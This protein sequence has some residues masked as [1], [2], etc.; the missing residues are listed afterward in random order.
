MYRKGSFGDRFSAFIVDQILTLVI[1]VILAVI[2]N[3]LGVNIGID[4]YQSLL[5]L[6]F[7]VYSTLFV[8]RSG[9][10]VGK[11]L[12][13][14]KVV[15]MEYKPVG[16]WRALLRE[17]IGKI[18]SSVFNLGYLW[19]IIDK[20]KQAWHDKLTRTLVVKLDGNGNMVPIQTEE[21]VTGKK[22]LAFV[23][24]FLVVGIPSLLAG[25]FT[26]VYLF[27]GSPIKVSGSAMNP[28]YVN[29][30]YYLTNKVAYRTSSPQRNDIVVFKNP[31]NEDQDFL[32][33]I[34]GIPGDQIKIQD[35]KAFVNNQ[36]LQEPYLPEST[37]SRT[38]AFLQ[39]GV[40]VTVPTDN[41]FVLGD[42]R[43][44]SSDSREWG[45]VPRNNIIGKLGICYYKCSESAQK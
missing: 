6:L 36:V 18:I 25:L 16:F 14:L 11:R 7:I 2:L 37:C 22:K 8:W 32:K 40:A 3:I 29:G 39:E 17:S 26:I 30:Q 10:T 24:L 42:N 19:V 31:K 28:N 38:G 33:R 20:R 4:N 15:D 43:D 35:C 45:F 27:I 9:A 34:I 12:L 21:E 41:Y 13:K 1:G 44:H 23:L 5:G